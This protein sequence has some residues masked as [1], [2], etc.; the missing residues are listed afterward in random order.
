MIDLFA[1]NY[2]ELKIGQREY[3][4]KFEDYDLYDNVGRIMYLYKKDDK[5]KSLLTF[6]IDDSTGKCEGKAVE[7]GA[8]EVHDDKLYLYTSWYKTGMKKL[9]PSGSR[10]MIYEFDKNG[11]FRLVS[12]K[13][14]IESESR[15]VGYDKGLKYLFQKP[16]TKEQKREL[17]EYITR[18]QKRYK[19]SFVF[20][21]KAKRV[22]Q[23]VNEAMMRKAETRWN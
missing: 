5:T 14:Y 18:M 9:A 13:L 6:T 19:G 1:D 17:Q 10:I 21:N 15:D 16:I 12:S 3:L 23:E 8:Y 20:G 11:A 4:L 7:E 2:K 22:T